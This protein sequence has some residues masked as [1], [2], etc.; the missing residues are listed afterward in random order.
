MNIYIGNLSMETTADELRDVFVQ[1]GAVTSVI[2]MNDKYIGSGQPRAYGYVEM[3]SKSEGFAAIA[4]L[5]GKTLGNRV[6]SVV[7]AR[8]MDHQSGKDTDIKIGSH[9]RRGERK[10]Q[11]TN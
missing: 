1:F 5:G 4:N 11:N 10:R 9:K 7:E 2:V 8:P 3:A 6:I